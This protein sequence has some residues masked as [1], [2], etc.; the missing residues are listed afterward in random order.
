MGSPLGV[1]KKRTPTRRPNH[2]GTG[3]MAPLFTIQSE[4]NS[5]FSHCKLTDMIMTGNPKSLSPPLRSFDS[6]LLRDE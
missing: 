3:A 4:N 6:G 2:G 5:E 1:G